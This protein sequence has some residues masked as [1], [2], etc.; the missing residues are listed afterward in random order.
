M[1]WL[2]PVSQIS[3]CCCYCQILKEDCRLTLVKAKCDWTLSDCRFHLPNSLPEYVFVCFSICAHADSTRILK[4]VGGWG[5]HV[6]YYS[7]VVLSERS[8]QHLWT[9]WSYPLV[10]C[11][12]SGGGGIMEVST[13]QTHTSSW[14]S[15]GIVVL[16][17][18]VLTAGAT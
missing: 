10:A 6:L 1:G 14:K 5:G 9:Y 18:F 12:T 17:I 16:S 4:E 13:T 8:W 7:S 3:P 2:F 15:P 11:L